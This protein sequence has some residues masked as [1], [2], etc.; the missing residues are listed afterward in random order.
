MY[1]VAPRFSNTGS[2]RV[3]DAKK[4]ARHLSRVAIWS[5]NTHI[6]PFCQHQRIEVHARPS[7]P[8]EERR[9]SGR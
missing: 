3:K 9:Q 6:V 1:H 7:P 4:L 8:A 2:V 5:N